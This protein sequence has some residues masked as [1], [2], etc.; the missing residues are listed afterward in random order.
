MNV[1][2]ILFH[3]YANLFYDQGTVKAILNLKTSLVSSYLNL[4]EQTTEMGQNAPKI[5]KG[6]TK[7]DLTPVAKDLQV[8][9][10]G[11]QGPLIR[12]K[13]VAQGPYKNA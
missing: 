2:E 6:K 9:I 13:A 11:R 10:Q 3:S 1:Y 7:A 5:T 8:V 4:A 12:D